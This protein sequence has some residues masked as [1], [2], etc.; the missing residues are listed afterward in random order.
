MQIEYLVWSNMQQQGLVVN[1][2]WQSRMEE[3][4]GKQA[5]V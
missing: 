5:N 4:D 3:Y 1:C 2:S